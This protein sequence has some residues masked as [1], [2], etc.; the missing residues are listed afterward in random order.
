MTQLKALSPQNLPTPILEEWKYTNL[1]RAMPQGLTP[2]APEEIVI[3]RSRGQNGGQPEDILWTGRDGMLQAPV[4][5]VILEEG[6]ELTLI[7]RHDG[8][9]AY[10]K[11]M[12]SEITLGANARFHHIRLQ[13]DSPA[14]IHTNMVRVTLERDSVYDGFSLNTGGKL[15]RHEIHAILKGVNIECSFNGL[16]L[17]NGTQH[18]D[19]TILMEHAAPHGRSNQFYRTVLDDEA[20]GVFQGKV[21]VHRAAQKT[22][23]YQLSN[24][25]L[26]SQKAEMDTK[27]ELEIYADD[28]K[29]SH[30]A[31]TG[32]LDEEPLFYLRSRGLSDAEARLLLMDAYIGEVA[33]KIENEGLKDLV[34]GKAK[35][36]LRICLR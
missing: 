15:S 4:L 30:G 6:A 35:D 25:I 20:R 28:V 5:K 16:N 8:A 3:H 7:E 19:T 29:C 26:L 23:G 34:K 9:G 31:T 10:W 1:P 11:N 32:Q 22:D 18:G 17:L 27:P 12:T 36:W 14:A 2:L 33:E 13:E 24:A 21:H